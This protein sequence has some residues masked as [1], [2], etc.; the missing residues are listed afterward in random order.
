MTDIEQALAEIAQEPRTGNALPLWL[1]CGHAHLLA[2]AYIAEKARA[3][4]LA[5][6]LEAVK[7][8]AQDWLDHYPEDVFIEP[9]PGQHGQT[10]DACSARAA[11]HVLRGVLED[12]EGMVETDRIIPDAQSSEGK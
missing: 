2:D 3:D 6:R 1:T 10:V 11:R 7:A 4:A 12:I 8:I 9:P 5:K